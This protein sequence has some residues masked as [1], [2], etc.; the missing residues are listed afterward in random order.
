MD[1]LMPQ[2]GETVLE[3]TIATWYKKPGDAV[4]KGE[5]LLDVET[6][7]AATEIEV[8]ADGVLAT[9]NVPEGDTVDVGTVLAVITV[10]GET[11]VA[12]AVE[13]EA[14]A[15]EAQPVKSAKGLPKKTSG[16]RIS[17]AVRRLL[18]QHKLDISAIQGTGETAG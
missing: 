14:S 8:P 7:K 6:D 16:E 9:I 17:P 13:E 4:S 1:V 3:G 5:M 11:A 18:K 2:L 12:A 10:E 15:P